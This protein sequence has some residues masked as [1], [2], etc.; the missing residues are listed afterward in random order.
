M[1][2]A[3]AIRCGDLLA[4]DCLHRAAAASAAP[5][6]DPEQPSPSTTSDRDPPG[7]GTQPCRRRCGHGRHA[8]VGQTPASTPNTGP[9]PDMTPGGMT[10]WRHD[11]RP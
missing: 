8:E 5:V 7:A 11:G 6:A 9:A 10:P 1:T 4:P 3:E 2:S